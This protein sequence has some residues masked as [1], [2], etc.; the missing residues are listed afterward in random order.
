MS[1]HFMITWLYKLGVLEMCVILFECAFTLKEKV[2]LTDVFTELSTGVHLVRL[3]EFISGEKLPTPSRRTLR[4]H[5]LENNS[6]AINFLKSKV[7]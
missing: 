7:H 6:I 5:C 3:L 4:V 2:D 1:S